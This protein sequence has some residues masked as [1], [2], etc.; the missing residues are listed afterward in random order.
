MG[1]G[2]AAHGIIVADVSGDGEQ[3]N[4]A[5]AGHLFPVHL[6]GLY[7]GN[8]HNLAFLPTAETMKGPI[9]VI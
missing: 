8:G 7:R 3:K 5:L 9:F 4:G 6:A 1:D 2:S